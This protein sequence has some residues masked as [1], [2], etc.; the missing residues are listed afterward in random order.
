[1]KRKLEAAN[2]KNAR[3][4]VEDT[5]SQQEKIKSS[6]TPL[7][8]IPYDEQVNFYTI[9]INFRIVN[10]ICNCSYLKNK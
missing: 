8:N 2:E 7:C 10:I 4:K 5:R 3:P 6:T 1:M 9:L